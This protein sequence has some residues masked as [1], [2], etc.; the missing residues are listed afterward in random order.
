M[1][2]PDKQRR[3]ELRQQFKSLQEDCRPLAAFYPDASTRHSFH[4]AF[5][6]RFLPHYVHQNP[7]AFSFEEKDPTRY[8]QSRWAAIFE[9]EATASSVNDWIERTHVKV[10]RRLADLS[11]SIHECAGWH[12]A[13]IRMPVPEQPPEAFFVAVVILASISQRD[14]WPE[15]VQARVF[16]LEWEMGDNHPGQGLIC[17]WTKEGAHRQWGRIVASPEA[18]LQAIGILLKE[19]MSPVAE[20]TPDCGSH[21]ESASPEVSREKPWWKFW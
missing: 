18:F 8:M 7:R 16:T 17:E 12:V 20:A 11:M 19:P 13:L 2:G 9:P 14:L 21:P 6:H 15:D 5:A 3:K 4:Y 10:F 1:A